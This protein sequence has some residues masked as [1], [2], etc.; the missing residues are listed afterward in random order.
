MLIR[1]KKIHKITTSTQ[2]LPVGITEE[3]EPQASTLTLERNDIFILITD[4][5]AE[6]VNSSGEEYSIERLYKMVIA[7]EDRSLEEIR[8]H[9]LSDFK[10]FKG[11]IPFHDDVTFLLVRYP[12]EEEFEDEVQWEQS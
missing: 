6:Q 3:V 1:D 2:N 5:L 10:Q 9:I 7:H 12:E 8:E 11:E 4:G